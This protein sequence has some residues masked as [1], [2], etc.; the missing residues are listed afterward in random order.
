MVPKALQSSRLLRSLL[1]PLAVLGLRSI[2]CPHD[3]RHGLRSPLC[4][5]RPWRQADRVRAF[6]GGLHRALLVGTSLVQFFIFDAREFLTITLRKVGYHTL[7]A[8]FIAAVYALQRWPHALDM[9]EMISLRPDA[10]TTHP[11]ERN[12]HQLQPLPHP[13]RQHDGLGGAHPPQ[14]RP[15]LPRRL[16]QREHGPRRQRQSPA[17]R[18]LLAS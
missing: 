7:T 13:C 14:K 10:Q 8:A 5:P 1:P 17:R 6:A 16:L 11:Y 4:M 3:H 9:A 15:H 2:H 18:R 12:G